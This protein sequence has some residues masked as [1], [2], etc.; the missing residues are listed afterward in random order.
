ILIDAIR[1]DTANPDWRRRLFLVPRAHV[2]QLTVTNGAVSGLEVW[3]S[4]QRKSLTIPPTCAV[5]LASGTIESTRLALESFPTPRM[6][7]NL[8]AHLRSNTVVR[9]R[10]SAFSPGLPQRLEAAALLVRGSTPQGRFHLQV[11]GAAVTGA[12]SEIDMWR[13]IP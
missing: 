7:R 12:N 4:G 3:I 2:T 8:M 10:R 5:V 11:T 13:M 6:G 9:I 1:Q